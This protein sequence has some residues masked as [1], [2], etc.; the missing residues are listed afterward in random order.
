[1]AEVIFDGIKG[2]GFMHS[3]YFITSAVI[4]ATS[5]GLDCIKEYFEGRL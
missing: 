1:M 2:Y 3:S 4:K 5:L